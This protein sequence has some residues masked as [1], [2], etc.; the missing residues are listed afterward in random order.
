MELHGS[1]SEISRVAV[2]GT[3]VIGR[4]WA[5]AFVRAGC[6]VRLFDTN[7][8]QIRQVSQWLEAT[9]DSDLKDGLIDEKE[10]SFR[11]GR[12]AT[13]KTV[14][15]AV[16]EAEYVQESGPENIEIKR[17]IFAELDEVAS[18]STVLGSSTS[19]LDMTG[20]SRGLKGASRCVVA[21]PVNPPH[22]VP[23][24]E[25]LPGDQTTPEV[26]NRTCDFLRQ[27]GQKPVLI[28][29][30]LRGFL[31]NRMQAALIREAISLAESGVAS[32]EAIDTVISDGLGLRWALMGPFGVANTNA[33]GGVREYFGRYGQAYIDLMEDLGSTPSFDRELIERLGKGTD[34]MTRGA[35]REEIRRWRDRMILRLRE[36]KRDLRQDEQAERDESLSPN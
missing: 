24:V 15:E 27:I 17:A 26:V 8:D 31:L 14:A 36:L 16:A 6:E 32:I 19:T 23:V 3:G 29:F 10:H 4:S 35:D 12:F 1:N 11:R 22:I 25:I 21:H 30:Y 20:I 5:Y 28:N 9:L 33:D 13:V 34:E 18:E 2:V 7:R